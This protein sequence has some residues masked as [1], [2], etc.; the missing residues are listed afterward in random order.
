MSLLADFLKAAANCSMSSLDKGFRFLEIECG[1]KK[2]VMTVVVNPAPARSDVGNEPHE[3]VQLH[4]VS[5]GVLGD[6]EDHGTNARAGHGSL[7]VSHRHLVFIGAL[8][9]LETAL[10][11]LNQFHAIE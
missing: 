4:A 8:G 11:E 10:N 3:L 1:V 5:L 9:E 7:E 6:L 2:L